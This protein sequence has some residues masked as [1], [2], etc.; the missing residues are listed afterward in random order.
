MAAAKKTTTKRKQATLEDRAVDAALSLIAL[1]GW[2]ETGL[3]DIAG[4]AGIGLDELRRVFPGRA[5]VLSAIMA[6]FDGA[7][8]L[9]L[10]PEIAEDPVRDRLF[11]VVM[12]QLDVLAPH[13]EAVRNLITDLSRE[14]P[15]LACFLAGPMRRSVRWMLEAARV[16]DWGPLQPLQEKGMGLLYLGVLRVWL[17]D[18]EPELSKTMAAL[19]KGLARIDGLIGFLR[20]RPAGEAPTE[21]AEENGDDDD[22]DDG[23]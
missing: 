9:D 3:R 17:R 2:R 20:L 14:L 7:M 16:D 23:A 4:E 13:K 1:Q 8:L 18:E 19:D 10:D 12:R 11:D 15:A 5:A 21:P 22:D 6:R